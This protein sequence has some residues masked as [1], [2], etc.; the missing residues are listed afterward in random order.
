MS[1]PKCSYKILKTDPNN[2][3][4]FNFIM[5]II[6][7]LEYIDKK[8]LFFF[9]K[10]LKILF[11]NYEKILKIIGPSTKWNSIFNGK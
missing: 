6:Y 11:S 7:F 4:L 5:L 3:Q 1:L 10:R 8:Q 9:K 2:C